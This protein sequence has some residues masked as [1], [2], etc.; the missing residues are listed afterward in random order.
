ML[1]MKEQ[2]KQ[3]GAIRRFVQQADPHEFHTAL[4]DLRTQISDVWASA[5]DS[6]NEPVLR[7]L[8]DTQ[9]RIRA[10]TGEFIPLI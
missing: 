6:R 8:Q 1:S 3:L 2:K 5:R 9:V 10:L 7:G 4:G